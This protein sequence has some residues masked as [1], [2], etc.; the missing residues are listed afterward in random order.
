MLHAQTC[1]AC[2]RMLHTMRRLVAY[3]HLEPTCEMPAVVR[4]Q[5][6]I[7]IRR[8]IGS[9]SGGAMLT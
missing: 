2:A 8:E 3:Y 7:A 4:Q 1:D 9:D 5:L 6:W